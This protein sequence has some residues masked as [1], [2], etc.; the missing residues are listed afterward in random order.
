MTSEHLVELRREIDRIDDQL[1]DL[2][3]ERMR[4]VHEIAELKES[5]AP[6]LRPAR[7]AAILRRLVERAGRRFPADALIRIWREL[8]AAATRAQSPFAVAVSDAVPELLLLARDHFGSITPNLVASS[9]AHALRML[10][11][12]RASLALLPMPRDGEGWWTDMAGGEPQRIR[13]VLRLP[14]AE[15]G[16]LPPEAQGLVFGNLP[17]E[18]SGDDRTLLGLEVHDQVSRSRLK[19]LLEVPRLDPLW[20]GVRY[21][22]ATGATSHLIEVAG[23]HEPSGGRIQEALAGVREHVARI[24]W[25]GSYPRPL[26]PVAGN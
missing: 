11:E 6:A 19:S 24:S 16:E 8:F 14:F 25:L 4:R 9:S 2:L 23:F 3:I 17:L 15:Y 22:P 18:P 12:G 13:A 7:E 26:G 21:H 10:E 5:S 20:L 1:V